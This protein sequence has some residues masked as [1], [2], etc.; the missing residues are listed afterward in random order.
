M[1]PQIPFDAAEQPRH[2]PA[3][4]FEEGDPELRIEF[5]DAAEHQRDQRQLHLGRVAGDMAHEAVFAKAR[6]DR[7]IVGAGALMEAQRHV[8]VLQ[9]AVERVPVRRMPV[10]A[11]DVIG[12]HK[13]ADRAVILDAAIKLLA[14]EVNVVDRQHRRHLQLVRA[15]LH[16]IVQPI[17]VGAA[18]RGRE[19]RV[20]VVARHEGEADRR[21]Q[22]GDVDPLHRHAHDLRHGVVAALDRE[23]H[24]GVGAL[25]DEAAAHPVVLRDVAVI[26]QRLAVEEP[27]RPA[28]HA[29][30][31]AIRPPQRGGDARLEFRVEIFV[32]QI[33]RLHDVHV[34]I[35]KPV[36]LFHPTSPPGAWRETAA[37]TVPP[38]AFECKR[39]M[40]RHSGARR[41]REPGI[42]IPEARVH[43]FRASPSAIPE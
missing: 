3:L 33:R 16:E 17:V 41:R 26:A 25:R 7:R 34:A 39:S 21:E 40:S 38:P 18:D 11:V 35:D 29:G 32:E 12:P 2:P 15:V 1:L 24:I 14:S 19:L 4:R 36:A 27:S 31:A 42:H 8:E 23:H 6:L 37:I 9:Q 13:G 28:A 30:G 10:A 20:H 22:H 5:E 43:G